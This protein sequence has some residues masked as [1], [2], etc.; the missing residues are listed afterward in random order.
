MDYS[1]PFLVA[2]FIVGILRTPP[3]EPALNRL[4]R[5]AFFYGSF[6][7]FLY[8]SW[9]GNQYGPRYWWESFPF[10]GITLGDQ[11]ARWWRGGTTALKKFLIGAL[12]IS[13]PAAGWCFY[14]QGAF[15]EKESRERKALYVLA[16]QTLEAPAIVFIHGFLGDSMVIAEE[17]AVRNS[18]RLD[19]RILYA[20][21]LGM[22]NVQLVKYYPD[23]QYY[24]GT[25]DRKLKR[26]V[27]ERLY[28]E[29]SKH[30]P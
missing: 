29:S 25:Y 2:L 15:L 10:L 7:Y 4:V 13:I 28:F 16:D 27:L 5:Y 20:H 12:L 23:R 6:V 9:G 8:Y 1:A 26:A 11:I 18:P 17:D 19:G 3:Q 21:D 14:K 30:E 24:R 22:K